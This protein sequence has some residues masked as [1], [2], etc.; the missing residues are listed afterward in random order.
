MNSELISRSEFE[1]RLAYFGGAINSITTE[2]SGEFQDLEV[3]F[4]H[5]TMMMGYDVRVTQSYLNWL[6]RYGSILCPSKIK[7]LL[8]QTHHDPSF[9]GV[10]VAY[11]KEH[12]PRPS[13]WKLL[14]PF[15]HKSKRVLFPNLPV[16]KKT[17][18]HFAKYGIVAPLLLPNEGQYLLPKKS[19]L[20]ACPELRYRSMMMGPVSSDIHSLIEKKGAAM[21][22]YE[23]AK[24]THHHKAQVYSMIRT[25]KRLGS[26]VE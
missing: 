20:K 6:I 7:K 8:K 2:V 12:D 10:F 19:V 24:V 23:M 17:N 1:S 14:G 5:A 13:R 9:L 26:W 3:F 18:P 16:P 15:T 11:L 21:T 4:I 25:M 22:A